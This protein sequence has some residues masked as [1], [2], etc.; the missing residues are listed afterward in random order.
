MEY[1]LGMMSR[2]GENR[3]NSTEESKQKFKKVRQPFEERS[4]SENAIIKKAK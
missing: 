3:I 2:L 1:C 4:K